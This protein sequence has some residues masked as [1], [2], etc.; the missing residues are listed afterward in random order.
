LSPRPIEFPVEG[1]SDGVV[2]LRLPA[3]ADIPRIVEACR[4]PDVSRYTTV[5]A[6]YQPH[7]TTEWMQRGLAGL[8]AGTDVHTV[9]AATDGSDVFGTI[10]LHEINRAASRCVAGYLVA[11]WA[12]HQGVAS[13]ALRLLCG[14]AFDELRLARVEVTIEPENVASRN[15]ALAV[16]FHEEGLLR[17]YLHI[18]GARRDMLMYSL[19]PS[20]IRAG[21]ETSRLNNA[22]TTAAP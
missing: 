4:D 22:G 9:I 12:R 8:A 7:H 16:G 15:T 18:A 20:D 3:D 2:R 6:N 19:L 14:Y 10:S 1:L 11:P 17:S 21:R 5:P 13:R